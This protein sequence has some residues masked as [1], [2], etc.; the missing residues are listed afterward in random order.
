MKKRNKN[1]EIVYDAE[2]DDK[3]PL[4]NKVTIA[5]SIACLIYL[6]ISAVA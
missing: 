3:Q 2:V 6:I 4:L 1:R 5:F